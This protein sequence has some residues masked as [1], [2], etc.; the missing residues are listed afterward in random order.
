MLVRSIQCNTHTECDTARVFS[1]DAIYYA[2]H[3]TVRVFNIRGVFNMASRMSCVLTLFRESKRAQS[4]TNKERQLNN[5]NDAPIYAHI[6]SIN[7]VKSVQ[8]YCI[9]T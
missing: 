7:Y 5:L 9:L 1:V 8:F 2:A 6:F 3:M 4:N